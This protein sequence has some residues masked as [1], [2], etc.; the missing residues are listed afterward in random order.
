MPEPLD[1]SGDSIYTDT[2]EQFLSS[3]DDSGSPAPEP[4]D[5][6]G[7]SI[8]TDTY[9]R[10]LSSGDD[11]GS[12]AP[13]PLDTS[14]DSIYTDT[15][16]RFL[17]SGDEPLDSVVN[18]IGDSCESWISVSQSCVDTWSI[19]LEFCNDRLVHL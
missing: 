15:Y 6:S 3:G 19:P 18:T 12:P 1:T 16:E 8:Y 4:L 7:D 14:G 13:E 10:F 2:Y 9:E 17:S 5:T 11:S